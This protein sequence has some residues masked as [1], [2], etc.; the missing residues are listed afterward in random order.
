VDGAVTVAGVGVVAAWNGR[1][2]G[3]SMRPGVPDGLLPA[4]LTPAGA[5]RGGRPEARELPILVSSVCC[6]RFAPAAALGVTDALGA[7]DRDRVE[8]AARDG[9][10]GAE[11]PLVPGAWAADVA[12][13]CATAPGLALSCCCF[14]SAFFA[15]W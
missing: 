7:A 11:D 5:P 14:C 8:G 15:L 12:P 2:A 9:C 13:P 1:D 3:G 6:V 4:P 10:G